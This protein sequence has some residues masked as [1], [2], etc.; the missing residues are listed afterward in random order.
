MGDKYVKLEELQYRLDTEA[1]MVE[2]TPGTRLLQRP[3][4]GTKMHEKHQ[5]QHMA[6]FPQPQ[7]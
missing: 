2:K 1:G 6:T 7:Q 5:F 4:A 3:N